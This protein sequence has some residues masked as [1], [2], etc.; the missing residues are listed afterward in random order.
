M[1]NVASLAGLESFTTLSLVGAE[2]SDVSP[3]A[4][5]RR[6][7][8]SPNRGTHAATTSPSRTA[9]WQLR[10]FGESWGMIEYRALVEMELPLVILPPSRVDYRN[11]L[12]RNSNPARR[13]DKRIDASSARRIVANPGSRSRLFTI[14]CSNT[15]SLLHALHEVIEATKLQHD[16]RLT[17]TESKAFDSGSL[18]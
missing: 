3:L 10:P 8:I 1:T 16:V 4:E 13:S 5:M 6:L 18:S 17:L 9:H 12:Y 2:V 14:T 15:P 7:Q 11:R